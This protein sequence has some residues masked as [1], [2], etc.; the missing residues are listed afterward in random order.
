MRKKGQKLS[1][2][3]KRAFRQIE[4]YIRK[5]AQRS[6]ATDEALA[7]VHRLL[8]EAGAE[9]RGLQELFPEGLEDFCLSVLQTLPRY[10]VEEQWSIG[11][12]KRIRRGVLGGGSAVLAAC[13]LLWYFGIFAYWSDGMWA[14]ADDKRNC[15][16][17]EIGLY[18][19]TEQPWMLEIDLRD[20]DSNKGKGLD[21]PENL[22]G[23]SVEV[24]RVGYL[25]QDNGK[26][27]Y[28]VEF[29]CY[30]DY[31]MNHTRY[32]YPDVTNEKP[33]NGSGVG[34]SLVFAGEERP[35]GIRLYGTG[36]AK[37]DAY[38]YTFYL[39]ETDAETVEENP[40]ATLKFWQ[41]GG[42]YYWRT[43]WGK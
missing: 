37:R 3:Y 42:N 12:V 20:L 19:G 9:G 29:A 26:R 35:N 17:S 32:Y 2:T 13:L 6:E 41:L 36:P 38:L 15:G 23:C 28:W 4:A 21:D 7:E 40:V 11:R 8:E 16:H 34:S 10:T 33:G 5:K 43:G 1:R 22:F 14:L 24:N 25:E 31:S 30:G 27:Q 39:M 18:R